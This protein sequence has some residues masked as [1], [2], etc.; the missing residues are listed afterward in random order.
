MRITVVGG[1][2]VG[3]TTAACLAT[4]GHSV[5]IYEADEARAASLQRGEVTFHE[6]GLDEL[7]ASGIGNGSLAVAPSLSAAVDAAEAIFLAVG[8]PALADGRTDEAQLLAAA[9][10]IGS[11]ASDA[12]VIVIKSTAPVGA[13]ERVRSAARDEAAKLGRSSAFEVVVNPEFLRAGY[14]VHDFQHPD[15]V[16]IGGSNRSAVDR[17]VSLYA[18]FVPPARIM[19]MDIASASLVK[20]AAN[21]MLATRISFMNEIANVAEAIGA[22]VE[23]VRKGVGADPRIGSAYLQPGM[24]YGGSCLPKDVAS[25]MIVAAD[26]GIDLK[27]ATAVAAVND[28]QVHRIADKL[29]TH[30]GNLSGRQIG[31]WGLAF[32]GGTDDLRGAPSAQVIGDLL[33]AGASIVAFDP[34]A[35]A[36]AQRAYAGTQ[37]MTIVPRAVDVLAGSDALVIAADWPEFREVSLETVASTLKSPL[38]VDGRNLFDPAAARAAGLAYFGIGRGSR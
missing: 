18:S 15:R 37:R 9:R 21:A 5:T 32:K 36:A 11:A 20:Y 4:N 10:A 14:A 24:G 7:V 16:I 29:R 17:I 2:Y 3:L 12:S 6:P 28:A 1:G 26:A 19:T 22:D 38:V 25:L 30:L 8:T 34:G 23:E 35:S 31:V 13:A 33:A 27:V